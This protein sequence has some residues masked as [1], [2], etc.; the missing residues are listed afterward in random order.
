MEVR[1]YNKTRAYQTRLEKEKSITE[2]DIQ[3]R[4]SWDMPILAQNHKC[5]ISLDL[6]V[7]NCQPSKICADVCYASQGRQLYRRAVVKSLAISRMIQEDP[8]RVAR[9]IVDEAEG[10][11][12]RLAGSGDI[13]PSHKR[14]LDYIE[15]FGGSWWGF[16]RRIDTHKALPRLMYSFDVSSRKASLNYVQASVP[17]A[18]RAYLRRPEDLEPPMDVAVVFPVHGPRTNYVNMVPESDY[19]CPAVRGSVDGCDQCQ[20]CY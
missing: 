20:R 17:V 12:I 9:K 18:R 13:L 2:D 10:H 7:H 4:M 11:P 14:L 6:P 16:T 8:E 15:E 19:D 5:Q 3:R 1:N